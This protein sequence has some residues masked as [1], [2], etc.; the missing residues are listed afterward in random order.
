MN[1]VG[2][3]LFPLNEKE[4]TILIDLLLFSNQTAHPKGIAIVEDKT[5]VCWILLP[6]LLQNM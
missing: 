2:A 3:Y 1:A 6:I 4:V 5:L